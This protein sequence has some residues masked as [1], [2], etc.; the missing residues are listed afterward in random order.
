M[1]RTDFMTQ[2]ERLLQNISPAEREEAIQYY[3]DYFDDAGAENEQEVIE[4]LG[5]PARV[6][7]N[8]KRDIL[9]NPGENAGRGAQASDRA[10]VEYGKAQNIDRQREEQDSGQKAYFGNET[11]VPAAS[12]A[13][14]G[15][16]GQ[17]RVSGQEGM[18][19]Q[20]TPG[21]SGTPGKSG[22]PSGAIVLITIGLIFVSPLL[23][24][25]L[26][27]V[28]GV[29]VTWL[30]LVFTFGIVALSLFI[31]LVVLVAVGVQCL[32]VDPLVGI[33]LMGGG[34]ICGGVG[35]IFLML[36][37]ALAGIVTPAIFRGVGRL[38]HHK[39]KEAAV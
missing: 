14:S 27:V 2:L 19:G 34:M 20:G 28:F 31:V 4:A 24:G 26:C 1:N 35:I 21:Q 39:K 5:N 38:F 10:M 15:A 18:P 11:A 17:E 33:A 37:V 22:M 29:L 12:T 8:I 32:F 16:Y 9:G 3:N 30:A 23:L 25:A 13:Q 6:A 36:T 7:E